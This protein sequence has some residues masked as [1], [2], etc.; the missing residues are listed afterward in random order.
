MSS[1]FPSVLTSYTNPAATDRLNSPSHSGIETNQNS[2]LGQLEKII[3]VEGASS[4]VGTLEYLIKSPGSDGGGHVQGV[5]K[6]GTNQTQYT[7]GDILVATSS[8]VLA[9][10]AVGADTQALFSDSTQSTG[11]KWSAVATAAQIQNQAFTY[12]RSSMQS[13]S[14]FA[15][16]PNPV[17]SMLTDGQSFAVKFAQTNTTSVL[18]LSVGATGPSSITARLKNTDGT[19]PIVGAI[20]ANMIG[21]VEFD[22][23]SSVFQLQN[24]YVPTYGTSSVTFL[25]NDAT[26]ATPVLPLYAFGSFAKELGDPTASIQAIP[27]G[28]GKTPRTVRLTGLLNTNAKAMTSVGRYNTTSVMSAWSAMSG[29][30]NQSGISTSII[31]RWYSDPGT[32]LFQDVEITTNSSNIVLTYTKAGTPSGSVMALWEAEA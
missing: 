2:G 23:V 20:Q 18:A 17:V 6:G 21:V 14:V 1:T 26:W 4:V 10:L 22:S 8:S 27:H 9:K 15:I 19:N 31:G 12:A 11:V 13:A 16:T 7:K 5:N 28:L 32:G 29:T 24:T 3:G 30:G 25:R